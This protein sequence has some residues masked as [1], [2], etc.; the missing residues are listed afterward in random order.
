M[1]TTSPNALNRR[2][3]L[4]AGAGLASATLASIAAA[5]NA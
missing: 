3:L 5:R 1:Q 2:S 4:L